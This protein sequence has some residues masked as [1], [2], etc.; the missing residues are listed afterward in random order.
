[1]ELDYCLFPDDLLY[2][3]DNNT[4]IRI[5]SDERIT[6][7][8]SSLL[9]AI[10][11]KLTSARL[12]PVGTKVDR[13]RS[14]GTLES[15]RFVG[16]VPSPVSGVVSEVNELVA[17]Q[18]KLLNDS[19]YLEGWI[20]RLKPLRLDDEKSLLSTTQDSKDRL[21]AKIAEFRARCFKA[22]PDHEMYEIGAECTAVLVRLNELVGE[23]PVGDVIHIVS[24]DPTAYVEMERWTD[25]T[26]QGLVDWRQEGNLFHFIVRKTR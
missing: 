13:G 25:D 19:P 8:V 1:M 26:G 18:P 6:I 2:D 9:S 20:A 16:P 5:E 14:L 4:W 11:G 21:K 24:D 7:G 3:V 12:R 15:V 17:K 10:A 22:F 23:I